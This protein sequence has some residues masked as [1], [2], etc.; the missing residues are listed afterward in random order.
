MT[1]LIGAFRDYAEAPKVSTICTHIAV[2]CCKV[3]RMKSQHFPIQH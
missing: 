3:L 2:V 1:K